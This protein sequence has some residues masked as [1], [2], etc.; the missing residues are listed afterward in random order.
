[1]GNVQQRRAGLPFD[2]LALTMPSSSKR[3]TEMAE[4]SIHRAESE[5]SPA[6]L[7]P[8]RAPKLLDRVRDLIR[9]KH[10]SRRTESA[11]VDWIR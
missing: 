8:V 3:N 9:A 7:A 4:A 5:T 6:T 11:Y 1:M 10:Y 2:D